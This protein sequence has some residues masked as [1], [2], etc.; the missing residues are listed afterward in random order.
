M[1][2]HTSHAH[3]DTRTRN[4]TAHTAAGT[5]NGTITQCF[6]PGIDNNSI[7]SFY[8]AVTCSHISFFFPT[9]HQTSRMSVSILQPRSALG[10]FLYGY[11]LEGG[12]RVC[13]SL[14]AQGKVNSLEGH[15]L[16]CPGRRESQTACNLSQSAVL[17]RERQRTPAL[18]C[19]F[20]SLL[21]FINICHGVGLRWLI[22]PS[23]LVTVPGLLDL[24]LAS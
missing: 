19:P 10:P 2:N 21:L 9:Q 8:D 14:T 24:I 5:D 3:G 15:S 4:W 22:L 16:I 23:I 18:S 1:L 12:Q 17:E 6:F 11:K 7:L 13:T 20:P